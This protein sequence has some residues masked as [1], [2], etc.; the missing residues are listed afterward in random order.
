MPHRRQVQKG[1]FGAHFDELVK[2]FSND[3]P[4]APA[5]QPQQRSAALQEKIDIHA[6]LFEQAWE[7]D[8]TPPDWRRQP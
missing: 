8:L 2:H 4:A 5:D 6:R 7:V 3:T 1:S